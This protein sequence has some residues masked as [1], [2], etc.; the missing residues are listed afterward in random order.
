MVDSTR[1]LGE[2]GQKAA[3]SV[4]PPFCWENGELHWEA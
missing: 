3:R 4:G 2:N 1:L